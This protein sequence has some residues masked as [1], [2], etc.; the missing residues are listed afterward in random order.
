MKNKTA[1][2]IIGEIHPLDRGHTHNRTAHMFREKETRE[3]EKK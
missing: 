3:S 1:E 2:S